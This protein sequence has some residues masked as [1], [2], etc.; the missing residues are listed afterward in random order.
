MELNVTDYN[1]EVTEWC[2]N[3][4]ASH[5]NLSFLPKDY[6]KEKV[7]KNRALIDRNLVRM[8]LSAQKIIDLVFPIP[9]AGQ[10]H[11]LPKEATQA[12]DEPDVIVVDKEHWKSKIFLSRLG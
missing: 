8:N 12:A 1:E 6:S 5:Y 10:I 2:N 11:G 7:R 3:I 9:T 4:L